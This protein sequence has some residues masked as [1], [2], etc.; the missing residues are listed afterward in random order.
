MLPPVNLLFISFLITIISECVLLV[1]IIKRKKSFLKIFCF[2]L[3]IHFITH[4]FGAFLYYLTGLSFIG[5]E[6]IIILIEAIF[7]WKFFLCSHK[8][9]LL[10]SMGTNGFSIIVGIVVRMYLI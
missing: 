3:L 7:Y 10:I 2:V 6:V 1:L 8:R 5:V 4:P 9:A